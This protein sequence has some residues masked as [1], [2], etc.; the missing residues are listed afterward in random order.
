MALQNW[1]IICIPP[2][3]ANDVDLSINLFSLDFSMIDKLLLGFSV[4]QPIPNNALKNLKSYKYSS[5]DNS[6]LSKYVL[7]H[8]W[9][10]LVKLFPLWMA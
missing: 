5:Q 2:Q 1:P 9:N 8:Y 10:W 4:R 6:L 3:V 7:V